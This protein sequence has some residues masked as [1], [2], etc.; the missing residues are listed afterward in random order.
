VGAQEVRW[1]KKGTER[2]EEY[3]FCVGKEQ[4]ITIYRI[5][6]LPVAL[7]AGKTWSL[8]LREEHWLNVFQN[9]VLTKTFGSNRE[10]TTGDWR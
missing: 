1:E 2:A 10:E 3:I 6:I 9:S 5:I 8:I 4:I 7:G